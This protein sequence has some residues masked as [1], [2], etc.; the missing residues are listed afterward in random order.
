MSSLNILY[1]FRAPLGGLFRQ[2]LDL[3]HFHHRFGHRVGIICD[4]LTGGERAVEVLAGLKE[5]CALGIHRMPMQRN[6][7]PTDL[8]NIRAI[9]RLARDLRA[10]VLHGHGSKGGLYARADA[11][12]FGRRGPVRAYTPH[13]GSFNYEQG[14]KIHAAYMLIER[15]LERGTDVFTFESQYVAD[16]FAREVGKTDKLV[17]IALNG[18]YPHEFA[19]RSLGEAPTD[20]VFMGELR[21]AKGIDLLITALGRLKAKGRQISTTVVGS[22]PDEAMLKRM[23]SE[24]GIAEATTFP[25][26]MRGPDGLKRGRIMVVPSR[27][28]SLPYI[29]LEAV[30]AEVP[31]LTTSCGGIGEIV[32]ADYPWMVEPGSVEALERIIAEAMDASPDFLAARAHGLMERARSL[33]DVESMAQQVAAAYAE[34]IAARAGPPRS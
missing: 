31:L 7:H 1:V 10:D 23:A 12:L 20:L 22:G 13:G 17:R 15:F 4:S 11:A 27:I 24:A 21:E 8:T 6:P 32:G 16:R 25:G 18:L 2:V 29:V 26:P 33:F 14:T 5:T 28:E 34:A 9:M 3:T 30:A 19:P